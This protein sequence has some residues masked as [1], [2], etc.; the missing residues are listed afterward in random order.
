MTPPL[1]C[2][3]LDL[4]SNNLQAEG[5]K[6]LAPAIAGSGSL[7]SVSLLGN[8]FNDET[9]L[10]LLKV[11]EETPTLVTLCGLTPD[12]MEASF[13]GW[14]LGPPEA[15]LLAPELAVHSSLTSL[16]VRRNNIS[17]EGASQISAAVLANTKIEKF[18]QIPIKEMRADSLTELNLFRKGIGIEGSMVV[19]GLMP[20]MGSLTK[21]NARRNALGSEGEAALHDAVQSKKGF[22]LLI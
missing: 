6:A 19:A 18:N 4:R 10:M 17:G 3:Q 16:D 21:L 9:A 7:T 5:A 12:Q 13:V 15:K 22:E 11:K 20:F 8:K 14:D 2:A 1:W